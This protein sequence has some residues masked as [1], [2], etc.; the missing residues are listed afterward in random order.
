MAEEESKLPSRKL[1]LKIKADTGDTNTYTIDVPTAGQ[2]IDIESYKSMLSK[3]QYD[4][5]VSSR[6]LSGKHAADLV[7]MIATFEVLCPQIKKDLNL[8]NQSFLDMSIEYTNKL[9]KVYAKQF[10]PWYHKWIKAINEDDED[11]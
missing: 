2:E 5:M 9:M 1:E 10:L 7:D 8:P 3:G 4:S 11:E 6:Y